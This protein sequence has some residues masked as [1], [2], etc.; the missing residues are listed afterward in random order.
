MTFLGSLDRRHAGVS[1]VVKG[2]QR[3]ILYCWVR[4]L[5]KGKAAAK[6]A[7]DSVIAIYIDVTDQSSIEAAAKY[8]WKT[9][10]YLDLLVKAMSPSY[11]SDLLRTLTGQNAQ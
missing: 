2:H 7:G 5:A 3:A 1:P 10:G 4:D 11:L 6:E 9:Y 8:I